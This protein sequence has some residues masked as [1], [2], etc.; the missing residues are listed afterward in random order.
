MI[1]PLQMFESLTINMT[2]FGLSITERKHKH[3]SSKPETLL[4]I[5]GLIVESKRLKILKV[6]ANN[7]RVFNKRYFYRLSCEAPRGLLKG[8]IF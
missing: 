6:V 5:Y 7:C 8:K 3:M 4:Y 1:S 2:F